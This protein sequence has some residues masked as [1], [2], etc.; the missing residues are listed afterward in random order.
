MYICQHISLNILVYFQYFYYVG[1]FLHFLIFF[2]IF[3]VF[4]EK[5]KGKGRAAAGESV[6]SHAIRKDSLWESLRMTAVAV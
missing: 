4:F 6:T 1:V 2:D 3:S 5:E